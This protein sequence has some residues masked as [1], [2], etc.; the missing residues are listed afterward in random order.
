MLGE[1]VSRRVLGQL[2][3]RKTAANPKTN[4]KPNPNPTGGQFSSGVIVW[5]SPTL[6]LFLTL[7]QSPT[8]TGDNFPW[9]GNCLDTLEKQSHNTEGDFVKNYCKISKSYNNGILH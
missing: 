4:P 9:E 5:L 8:L 2:H 6:K 3:S 7:N 1:L